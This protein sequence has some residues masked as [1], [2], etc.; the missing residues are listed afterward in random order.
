MGR[1]NSPL[2]PPESTWERRRVKGGLTKDVKRRRGKRGKKICGG[3]LMCV[4]C[5]RKA[6]TMTEGPV[7][8]ARKKEKKSQGK[9]PG[10]PK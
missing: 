6:V 5:T 7:S 1:R 9:Q 2:H 3:K 4:G 8:E 10:K